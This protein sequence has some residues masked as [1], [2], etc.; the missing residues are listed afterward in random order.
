[1]D[2]RPLFVLCVD[3]GCLLYVPGELPP[4]RRAGGAQATTRILPGN[5]VPRRAPTF[6]IVCLAQKPSAQ[7]KAPNNDSEK[8]K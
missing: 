5:L 1:M 8:G 6:T 4:M 7:E 2:G 3:M